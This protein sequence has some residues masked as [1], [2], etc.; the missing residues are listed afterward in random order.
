MYRGI[1][2]YEP[3][4]REFDQAPGEIVKG[5]RE[6]PPETG[7][8]RERSDRGQNAGAGIHAVRGCL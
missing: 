6:D 3:V 2:N 1:G 8:G 7:T 5:N 4:Y